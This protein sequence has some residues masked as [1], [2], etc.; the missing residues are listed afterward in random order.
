[1]AY[2]VLGIVFIAVTLPFVIFVIKLHPAMKGMMALGDTDGTVDAPV[3]AGLNAGEALKNV[4]FWILAL[5]FLL[6]ELVQLGV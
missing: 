3:L 2:I 4:S 1:M 6:L 5:S